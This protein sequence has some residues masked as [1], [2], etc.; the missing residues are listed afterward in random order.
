MARDQI[1]GLLLAGG[2]GSRMGGLDK[3]LQTLNG[4]PLF[5]H[6]L[7]RLA[8]QV[9][10]LLIS[11]NRNLDAYA[12]AGHPLVRDEDDS[13]AGPLAGWLAGLRLARTDWLLCVPCDTP[14][15]PLDLAERL[16]EAALACGAKVAVPVSA[17][18][19][20]TL[21]NDV[22]EAPQVQAA[23]CLMRVELK[24]S[25]AAYLQSGERK[26]QTWLRAQ[27]AVPVPFDRP[28]DVAAF[29]N[30]NSLAELQSLEQDAPHA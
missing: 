11:A 10:P 20:A 17:R 21:K 25:L 19:Q 22:H 23:F 27:K 8:P 12:A 4:R 5:A 18:P 28:G 13:Y 3:G 14:A 16:A 6:V 1:T 24:D 15:L 29:F 7:S 2:R 9:G 30:A 26:I